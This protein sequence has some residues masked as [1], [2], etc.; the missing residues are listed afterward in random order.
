MRIAGLSA[1]TGVSVA[2]LKYYLREGLL[3]PGV[4]TAV[5]QADYDDTHVRRVRLIRALVELGRL[6]I[7]DAARVLRAVDDD[8]VSIHEAFGVAQ[9]AMVPRRDRDDPLHADALVEV[10]RLV[11]RNRLR[12]RPD[13]E[14]R[15]MLAEAL[16]TLTRFDVLGQGAASTEVLDGHLLDSFV[17]A[18]VSS[19]E[20]EIGYV[21]EHGERSVQMTVTVVGTIAWEVAM[22]AIRRMALEH[23]SALRF[24]PVAP[25]RRQRV[26]K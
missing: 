17:A 21:P 2:T 8:D 4:A 12:V 13:A 26:A 9:D 1:A 6:S 20:F 16:I 24:D 3:H 5:N 14:V 18:A 19:A 22:D 10:D 25:P 11:E 15:H 23:A 7:A